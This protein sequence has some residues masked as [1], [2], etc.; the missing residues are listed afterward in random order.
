[1]NLQRRVLGQVIG[2]AVIA[3][4]LLGQFM[5]RSR[6]DDLLAEAE[7]RGRTLLSGLA[8]EF[9]SHLAT[10]RI[11]AI[12]QVLVG[13]RER[14]FESMDIRF[15]AV[16]DADRRVVGHTD[17]R[18]YGKVLDAAF[19]VEA[20][21][22]DK[23]LT[24]RQSDEAADVLLVST[25]VKTALP[26]LPGIRW[27]TIL[28]GVDLAP[29]QA[30]LINLLVEGGLTI[31]LLLAATGFALYLALRRVVLKPVGMLEAAARR[32][33]EGDSSARAIP[34]HND[35]IGNLCTAFNRMADR[36]E[37]HTHE[38]EEQ[39]TLR[40]RELED[41]NNELRTATEALKDANSRLTSLAITDGLT[42]LFNFRHLQAVL[43]VE[44]Q[45]AIRTGL[46]L[47]L[48]MLDVDHFKV[49]NDTNGHPA[50]DE[51]LKT[52][53]NLVRGRIRMTDT[54]CRYG[55][56]EFAIVLPATALGDALRVA[57]AI[58]SIV[59]A[60]PFPGGEVQPEGRVT[61]SLG[62]ATLARGETD[63]RD[64][65]ALVLA[66]DT[67]LYRAKQSG[68]NRV[69]PPPPACD[70]GKDVE[71]PHSSDVRKNGG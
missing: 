1:M 13:F 63:A 26:G 61:V 67:A 17:T 45:R 70:A 56:E 54:P 19:A 46:P 32:F 23:P 41:R 3:I 21:G 51:V 6:R 37:R 48:V 11:E 29:V 10:N 34:G 38:L 20:A 44:S 50:G 68:R 14:K 16:L 12:D 18:E 31:L 24:R 9:S 71:N 5:L 66:A 58:R 7:A 42:G 49:F 22:V 62:V 25:P 4:L 65:N 35:E 43:D 69:E 40:T 2:I 33:A 60:H 28:A 36:I 30:Q 64:R 52:I 53:A 8:V 15:L 27:G 47:S 59:E 57:D 55:G 39:V